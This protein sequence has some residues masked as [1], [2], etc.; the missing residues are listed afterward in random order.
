M[1]SAKEKAGID[2]KGR[3]LTFHGFRHFL[4]TQMVSAGIVRKTVGHESE[5][6]TGR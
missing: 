1:D 2:D 6:M 4:N 3:N 5:E